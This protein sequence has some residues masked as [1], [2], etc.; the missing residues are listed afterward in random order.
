MFS[1]I[2]FPIMTSAPELGITYISPNNSIIRYMGKPFK[3]QRDPVPRKLH[4]R[5]PSAAGGQWSEVRCRVPGERWN[6]DFQIHS[7]I[8]EPG[9]HSG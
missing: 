3:F 4:G 5:V 7:D 6:S 1:N 2:E 9:G 8:Y